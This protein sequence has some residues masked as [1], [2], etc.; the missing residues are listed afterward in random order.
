MAWGIMSGVNEIPAN[1]SYSTL[2]MYD[3]GINQVTVLLTHLILNELFC[4][5]YRKSAFSRGNRLC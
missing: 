4:H 1:F 3:N 5:L 2:L